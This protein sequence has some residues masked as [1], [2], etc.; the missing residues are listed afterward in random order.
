MSNPVQSKPVISIVCPLYNEQHMVSVFI[1]EV[2]SV[3]DDINLDYELICVND[4]SDDRTLNELITK[5]NNHPSMRIINLSRNFGKE[6]ALTAGLDA[7]TGEVVIPIDADLQHPPELIKEF[8]KKWNEG[9]DVVLAKSIDRSVD[10]SAK[11]LT[12]RWF[13][14][15]YNRISDIKLPENVGDYRLMTRRVVESLKQL[16][17]NQRFMKGIFAWVGYPATTVEY[18]IG[19]RL[20]GTSRFHGW[21]LWNLALD[22]LTSFSTTPIRIWLYIGALVSLV[23]FFY[24][25][26]IVIKTVFFGVDVPGYASLMTII[27]FLG[28]IQLIGIGVLGEYIGR[29]YIEAKRRPVYIIENEY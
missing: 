18:S 20:A 10:S 24:G 21:K 12:S 19:E 27:L 25:S 13:Y 3:L 14:S 11:R 7:S 6:A 28:G 2:T 29:M 8:I 26:L 17:E 9:Y 1:D 5:K 23:S 16:P 15:V 22:G 4:G